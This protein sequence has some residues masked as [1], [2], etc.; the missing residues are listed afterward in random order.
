MLES[1]LDG[2]AQ[3]MLNALATLRQGQEEVAK[4]RDKSGAALK[5]PEAAS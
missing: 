3:K 1:E 2:W 5:P 4:Q